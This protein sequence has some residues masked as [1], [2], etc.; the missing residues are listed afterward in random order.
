[1]LEN[2]CTGGAFSSLF[3]PR[4][5]NQRRRQAHGTV[6]VGGLALRFPTSVRAWCTRTKGSQ[7][8]RNQVPNRKNRNTSVG[9]CAVRRAGRNRGHRPINR[10]SGGELT[11]KIVF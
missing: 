10:R 7:P 5:G 8:C 11:M 2:A 4:L 1:M 6:S 9:R 3:T